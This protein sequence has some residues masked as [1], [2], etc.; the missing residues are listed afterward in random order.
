M[1]RLWTK[2]INPKLHTLL[3][4][5]WLLLYQ[6]FSNVYYLYMIIILSQFVML[7]LLLF[8]NVICS[9]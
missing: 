5:T 9:E 1:D 3:M 2:E 6:F 4:Y 8:D 7:S